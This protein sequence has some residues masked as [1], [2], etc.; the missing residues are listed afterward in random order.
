MLRLKRG[1][2][3]PPDFF[4][5]RFPEDQF[6][7]KAM[8]IGSWFA[9]ID[10]HYK[11]NGYTQPDNWREIA[12][13]QLCRRLSGEWCDGGNPSTFINTRFTV[14][15][16]IRGT[17]VLGSFVLSGDD[18]VSPEV[19]EERALI[20]SRCFANVTVPGCSACSGMVNAIA[21]AKGAKATK[22]D[23]LLKACGVCHCSNEAQ[24]WIGAEHLAKGVTEE[25][26]AT[27]RQIDHCWKGKAIEALDKVAA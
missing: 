5:F 18:V 8:D 10:K 2:P 4:T 9:A 14:N 12:E 25:M 7:A 1:K 21:E 3:T 15:D 6:L 22:H 24:V 11:D 27:Y 16:F 13:D 23:H 19:A 17:A 20:C 26:M